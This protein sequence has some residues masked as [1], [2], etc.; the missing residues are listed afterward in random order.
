MFAYVGGYTTADRDGRGNGINVFGVDP[1]GGAW[2]HLQHIGGL[3]NPSLFTL[4]RA[5]TRLYS[6]HGGR[7]LVSA[8][9]IDR[10]S[11][12]LTL[13]NQVDCQGNNPVDFGA[14]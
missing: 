3:E 1:V 14:R 12:A 5:G 4:N 11:G 13:L 10:A 2:T 9:A 6:V 7:N 8:F